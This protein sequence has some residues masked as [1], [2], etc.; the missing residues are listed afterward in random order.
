MSSNSTHVDIYVDGSAINNGMPHATA[1]FAIVVRLNRATAEFHSALCPNCDAGVHTNNRAELRAAQSALNFLHE[2]AKI[3][4]HRRY[5]PGPAQGF[6]RPEEDHTCVT[7]HRIMDGNRIAATVYTDSTFVERGATR[8]NRQ[9]SHKDLWGIV[10]NTIRTLTGCGMELYFCHVGG[11]SGDPDNDRA[12]YLAREMALMS[13]DSEEQDYP[14]EACCVTCGTN[15]D[16]LADMAVHFKHVHMGRH[17]FEESFHQ[18]IYDGS[19]S[20]MYQCS[21]CERVL[22]SGHSMKQHIRDKHGYLLA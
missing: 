9:N 2:L 20:G 12:D 14:R 5:R 6:N 21:M 17:V 1:G 19:S 22:Q 15:F 4:H 8:N 13:Y 3:G 10:N 11:H 7:D 16:S 18:A